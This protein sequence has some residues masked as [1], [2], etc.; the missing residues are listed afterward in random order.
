LT[1]A[2]REFLSSRTRA[3][4]PRWDTESSGVFRLSDSDSEERL[5]QRDLQSTTNNSVSRVS[6]CWL[7]GFTNNL[8]TVFT[9]V[10]VLCLG[11]DFNKILQPLSQT[12]S[13]TVS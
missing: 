10:T 6:R 1:A 7:I 4:D 3:S 8:A 13:L 5:E 2:R 11:H 9:A 12:E